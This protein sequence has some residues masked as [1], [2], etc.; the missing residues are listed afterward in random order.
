MTSL[1]SGY[2]KKNPLKS[3]RL[4]GG[5]PSRPAPK[6][7]TINERVDRLTARVFEL[8]EKFRKLEETKRNAL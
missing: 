7:L 1:G 6:K 5:K 8:E 3:H 4:G 2:P